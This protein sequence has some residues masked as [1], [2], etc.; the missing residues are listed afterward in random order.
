MVFLPG[1]TRRSQ[2]G[3]AEGAPWPESAD[4]GGFYLRL[5]DVNSN[6]SLASSWIAS[7]SVSLSTNNFDND[8]FDF[9]VLSRA[10]HPKQ[11]LALHGE[12]TM[13]QAT[14]KRLDDLDNQKQ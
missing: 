1:H 12:D 4:G 3:H 8:G 10:A 11:F 6:N 5:V 7:S 14:F 9:T 13:L 2:K